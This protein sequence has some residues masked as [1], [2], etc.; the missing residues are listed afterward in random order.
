M[1]HGREANRGTQELPTHRAVMTLR[2]GLIDR[3]AA[4]IDI[5]ADNQR[6]RF[7]V[8]AFDR[9]APCGVSAGHKWRFGVLDTWQK[10]AQLT[11]V[12]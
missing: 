8:P 12:D 10:T 7:M 4:W 2:V 11:G 9:G 5:V 6:L 3:V 1:Q